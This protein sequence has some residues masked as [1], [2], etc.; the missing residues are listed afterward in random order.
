MSGTP[1]MVFR[2][3]IDEQPFALPIC[4]DSTLGKW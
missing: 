4:D 2:F 1:V 3:T